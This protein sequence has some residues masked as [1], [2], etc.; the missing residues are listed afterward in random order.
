MDGRL[1][2]PAFPWARARRCAAAALLLAAPLLGGCAVAYAI[3][4]MAQ[5]VEYQKQVQTPA[6]YDDLAGKDVAVV[7]DTDLAILYEHPGLVEKVTTGVTLRIGRDVPDARVVRP[8]D[9]IAWQWK[10]PQWNAMPYGEM[11]ASLNVDRVIY[12]DI[13]EYRL[14]PPGNRWLW[15]GVC[16]ASVNVIERDWID[17]DMFAET[18]TVTSRFPDLEGVDR[19]SAS[20]DQ[21]ETGL[22]ADFVKRTAW[23]FHE[24]LE[25]KYPE[26]FRPELADQ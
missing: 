8:S 16:A 26:Y 22:L 1:R 17:P 12:V 21:I 14:N 7:V 15:D 10:T 13:Y 11:A 4:G 2:L 24:H 20:A 9:I 3:G 19:T 6:E 18:F 25:P 5:N 23:L